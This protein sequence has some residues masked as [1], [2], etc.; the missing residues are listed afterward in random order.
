[1]FDGFPSHQV[2]DT[3]SKK[4]IFL[5]HNFHDDLAE[6]NRMIMLKDKEIKRLQN[7]ITE[8]ITRLNGKAEDKKKVVK[9]TPITMHAPKTLKS[10]KSKLPNIE[11]VECPSL[12]KKV[13]KVQCDVCKAKDWNKWKACQEFN[14][15]QGTA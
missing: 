14:R 15:E 10:P 9:T 13:T 11:Y 6:K 1:M 7:K 8:L 12:Q 2:P 3:F 4:M 5:I